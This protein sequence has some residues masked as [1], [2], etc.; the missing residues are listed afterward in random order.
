MTRILLLLLLV[1][2]LLSMPECSGCFKEFGT[3]LARHERTCPAILK[4]LNLDPVLKRKRREEDE[5]RRVKQARLD[6]ERRKQAEEEE[7]RRC[8]VSLYQITLNSAAH[9]PALDSNK[10]CRLHPSYS[11]GQDAS[12]GHQSMSKIWS[13]PH[14]QGSLSSSALALLP[15]HLYHPSGLL[16][17]VRIH[18]KH[19]LYPLLLYTRPDRIDLVF[20]VNTLV[21]CPCAILK[22][23]LPLTCSPTPQPPYVLP[24]TTPSGIQ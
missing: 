18:V 7:Q 22:K 15:S 9:S 4:A 12:V 19:P 24:H 21:H 8:E 2:A 6:K 13:Q 23:D 11:L 1:L 14:S 10:R 20:S 16:A 3:S 17:Y 5:E